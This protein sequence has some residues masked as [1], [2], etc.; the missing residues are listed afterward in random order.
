MSKKSC[1]IFKLLEV[2]VSRR[3]PQNHSPQIMS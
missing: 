2:L 1:Q 3:Y